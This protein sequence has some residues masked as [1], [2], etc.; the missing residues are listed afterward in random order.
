MIYIVTNHGTIGFIPIIG[1]DAV[2][3]LVECRLCVR[4]IRVQFQ[5]ES[6]NDLQKLYLSLPILALGIIRICQGLVSSVFG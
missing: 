6:K 3:E 2:A 1:P 5:V 4:K